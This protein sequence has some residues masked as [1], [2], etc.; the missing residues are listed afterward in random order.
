LAEDFLDPAGSPASPGE[1]ICQ[2]LKSSRVIVFG[3]QREYLRGFPRGRY[4]G[5]DPFFVLLT[6]WSLLR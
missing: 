1:I 2:R 4:A 3:D 5:F 6:R